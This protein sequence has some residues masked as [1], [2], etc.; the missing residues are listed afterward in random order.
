LDRDPAALAIQLQGDREYRQARFEAALLFYRRA[1]ARDSALTFA[2]LKGAQ[3]AHWSELL[4]E[5]ETFAAI[6]VQQEML[7]TPRYR[8][9]AHGLLHYLRGEADSAVVRL[10][11]ALELRPE[12]AEGTM[13]LAEVYHHL[14]PRDL[15]LSD[16]ADS[17]FEEA[18][19]MDPGFLPPL[20]HL[21]E[22]AL[23]E[24]RVD[25][26]DSLVAELEQINPDSARVG[27]L[28]VMTRCVRDGPSVVDWQTI[29]VVVPRIVL[30]AGKLLSGGASQPEC[31]EA[32]LRAVRGVPDAAH[33]L[34]WGATVTL[35]GL[36]V[37]QGREAEAVSLLD[38]ARTAGWSGAFPS[39]LLD[40]VSGAVGEE[41]DA[42]A[43]SA[44]D[45]VREYR[46]ND[47]DVITNPQT[48]W[49][50]GLWHY[51]H[52]NMEELERLRDALLRWNLD[53]T[54]VARARMFGAELS[55]R[56][57]AARGDTTLAIER[58]STIDY[59]VPRST[60]SWDIGDPL[61]ATYLFLAEL[62]AGQ[63]R[64]A[65]AERVATK[66]DHP[67]PA[68]FLPFI[69]ASLEFRVQMAEQLGNNGQARTYRHRLERLGRV[70]P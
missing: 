11:A 8:E 63:G 23:R 62:L 55:A 17:L 64:Y 40:A 57:L 19:R 21:A 22:S 29:A 38:S 25:D 47:Y 34:L 32:A 51:R 48:L 16:H 67:A 28:A 61:P 59:P 9:F 3:A 65:D 4:E 58:I 20:L 53:E 2:A 69:P 27:H 43:Q 70:T 5:A 24:G 52:A 12:W 68:A 42:R 56:L 26:A 14:L 45:L 10:G 60:V 31:A 41:M 46:N 44:V 18:W 15:S 33:N 35:Q 36:L 6:A 13:A 39:Y 1:L 54:Q 49:L 37:A 7:L 50:L 30:E 66:L